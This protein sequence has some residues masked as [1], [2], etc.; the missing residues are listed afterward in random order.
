MRGGLAVW[1]RALFGS[2]GNALVS[3]VML[4]LVVLA[5]PPLWHWLIE[6]ATWVAPNRRGCA[7]D[8]ACWAFIRARLGLFF[9]GGFPPDQRWRVDLAA[10]LMMA[11]LLGALFARRR[12]GVWLAVLLG[13]V[14]V[15]GGVLLAGG[16]FGL[17]PVQTADWG[18]LMLNVVLSFVAVAGAVPLG[19]LLALGRRSRLP[20]VHGLCVVMIEFWRGVPLLGVLFM[21]LVLLPM[22]LPAGM[23]LDNLLRALVVLTLFEAA[24]M[25]EAVRG[26]LQGVDHGQR[27]AASALGL[28]PLQANLTVVLPQALRIAVPGIINVVVDLFKD[29]TLVSIVGLFDL[30][31]VVNQSLKDQSW[32]GLAQEGY[33]FAALLFFVCCLLISLAGSVL[34]RRMARR[35]E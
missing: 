23:S 21:G 1:G 35:A 8:G 6:A 26:G 9:Y 30:M 19:T 18:G 20:F 16:V 33:A 3:V 14:P 22:V 12:R 7:A 25:A 5:A 17:A 29:T 34:E 13:G 15:V 24:Y 11:A 2:P 27:E 10:G 32:L 28:H 4:A 31:G